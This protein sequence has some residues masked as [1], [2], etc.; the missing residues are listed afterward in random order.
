M[1]TDTVIV[2]PAF[3]VRLPKRVRETLGLVPGQRLRVVQYGQRV[4]L[5][6]LRPV[7]EAPGLFGD[8]LVRQ[9]TD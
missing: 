7:L 3:Q 5:V 9:A 8:H 1:D 2:S 6:P 4:E